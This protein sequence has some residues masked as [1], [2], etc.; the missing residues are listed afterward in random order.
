VSRKDFNRKKSYMTDFSKSTIKLTKVRQKPISQAKLQRSYYFKANPQ[1]AFP[2]IDTSALESRKFPPL[3]NDTKSILRFI[4]RYLN[5]SQ[6]LCFYVILCAFYKKDMRALSRESLQERMRKALKEFFGKNQM[7]DVGDISKTTNLL[8]ALGLIA[9]K[10]VGEKYSNRY[11]AHPVFKDVLFRTKMIGLLIK[12]FTGNTTQKIAQRINNRYAEFK[13]YKKTILSIW[14]G[15]CDSYIKLNPTHEQ[16]DSALN[17]AP[18]QKEQFSPK[19]ELQVTSS[20]EDDW[21]SALQDASL[22]IESLQNRPLRLENLSD[23]M[24]YFVLQ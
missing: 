24:K 14:K 15:I 16:E 4:C 6:A 21:D 11:I 17:K 7:F 19:N 3:P 22:W 10:Y 1:R 8:D 23:S 9:K 13:T 18:E 5:R 20:I 2:Y 12:T